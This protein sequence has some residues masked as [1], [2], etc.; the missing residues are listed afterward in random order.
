M[1]LHKRKVQLSKDWLDS[2]PTW[3]PFYS[4]VTKQYDGR[5]VMLNEYEWQLTTGNKK[6]RNLEIYSKKITGLYHINRHLQRKISSLKPLVIILFSKRYV[7]PCLIWRYRGGSRTFFRRGCTRLLLY[8]NTNKP[9][10]FFFA[11]YQL[12]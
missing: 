7:W 1:F 6:P 11:E 4:F 10:S 2:T 3:L 12:Y 8:F 9:H 5:D